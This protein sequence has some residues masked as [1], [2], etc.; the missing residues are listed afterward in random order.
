MENVD[1][2][3][4]SRSS[5]GLL[6]PAELVR[7]A[8]QFGVTT[9][10]LTDHDDTSGLEEAADSARESGL[11]FV[12]GVE[13]SATWE[14]ITVHVLGLG[15]DPGNVQLVRGLQWVRSGRSR[16]ASQ[17]ADGLAAAGIQGSLEGAMEYAQNP[18]L[19]SR[20]HFGRFL[21]DRG[22]ARDFRSVFQKYLVSGK[23][24]YVA[25]QWAELGDA[26]DW[27]RGAGGVAILAHPA[28][29]KINRKQMRRLLGEFSDQGGLGLEVMTATHTADECGTFAA[30]A[31]EFGML[32][33]RGSDFH[34][35]GESRFELGALPAL[36][37][38]LKPVWE[39]L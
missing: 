32:A 28:R 24:G 20:T 7:R 14:G 33:S 19:I 13:I 25:H 1:L 3:C 11:R 16:R 8:R 34:A 22:Y 36:P 6:A 39:Q 15:I 9:L 27:I 26:L 38:G 35:P 30:L 18:D 4:H 5:D 29:Y 31:Q 12:P 17:I 10:A 21:V 2:H 37:D 23:P